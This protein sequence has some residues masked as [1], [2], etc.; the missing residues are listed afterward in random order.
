ML[1]FEL[2]LKLGLMAT[3]AFFCLHAGVQ[4]SLFFFK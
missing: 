1:Q 2:S 4:I 3:T